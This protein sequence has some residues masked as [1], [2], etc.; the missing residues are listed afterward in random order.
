MDRGEPHMCRAMV[1]VLTLMSGS[2]MVIC[3][4]VVWILTRH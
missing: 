2:A 3:S 4:A 1:G